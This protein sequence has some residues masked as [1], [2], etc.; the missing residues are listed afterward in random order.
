KIFIIE[1]NMDKIH[2][3]FLIVAGKCT[4]LRWSV[5][6]G[7]RGSPLMYLA[8]SIW[9]EKAVYKKF[10]HNPEGGRILTGIGAGLCANSIKIG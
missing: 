4:T 5:S 9:Q 3:G 6:G 8:P 1:K 7:F 2:L 10:S